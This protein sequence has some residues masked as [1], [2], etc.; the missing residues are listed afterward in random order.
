MR[1]LILIKAIWVCACCALIYSF[2]TH[3]EEARSWGRPLKAAVGMAASW[4][5]LSCRPGSPHGWGS[6]RG[7]ANSSARSAAAGRASCALFVVRARRVTRSCEAP[8][9]MLLPRSPRRGLRQWLAHPKSHLNGQVWCGFA[10]SGTL[11]MAKLCGVRQSKRRHRS[12]S[13]PGQPA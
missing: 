5:C 11:R 3:T 8:L 2:W 7:T 1:R 6:L 13:A 12:A 10:S 9:G 4:G